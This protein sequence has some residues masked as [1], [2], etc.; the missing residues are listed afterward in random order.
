MWRKNEKDISILSIVT[1]FTIIA[2]APK[3]VGLQME[4]LLLM[5]S[6]TDIG[7]YVEALK[8]NTSAFK[9]TGA[10]DAGVCIIVR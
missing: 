3:M 9:A 1:S 5:L 10:T 7:R 6:A 4:H 2:E 8:S